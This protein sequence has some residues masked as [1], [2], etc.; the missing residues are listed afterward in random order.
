MLVEGGRR[1]KFKC[2]KRK[3]GQSADKKCPKYEREWILIMKKFPSGKG[4]QNC[5][6]RGQD[7]EEIAD[8]ISVNAVIINWFKNNDRYS[9]SSYQKADYFSFCYRFV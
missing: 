3:K 4:S 7:K 1:S 5:K 6:Y 9:D 8:N 2:C